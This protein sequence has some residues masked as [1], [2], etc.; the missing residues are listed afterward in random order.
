MPSLAHSRN[1]FSAIWGIIT[2]TE[3]QKLI[4][5]HGPAG[6]LRISLLHDDNRDLINIFGTTKSLGG[7]SRSAKLHAV[8]PFKEKKTRILLWARYEL[9]R[10]NV[11]RDI[12][13]CDIIYRDIDDRDIAPAI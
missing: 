12:K 5:V 7:M 10:Y 3:D 6:D 8:G 2:F 11:R 13:H 4:N 9:L 1:S